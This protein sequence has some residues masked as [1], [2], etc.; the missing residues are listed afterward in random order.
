MKPILLSNNIKLATMS[1][2]NTTIRQ[3]STAVLQDLYDGLQVKAIL[4]HEE[5]KSSKNCAEKFPSTYNKK[6]RSRWQHWLDDLCLLCDSHRGGVTTTS[7]AV[8]QTTDGVAFWLAMNSGDLDET[9][10]HL[11]ALLDLV[12]RSR[13]GDKNLDRNTAICE[14]YTRAIERSPQRVKNYAKRLEN[15]LQLVCT[16]ADADGDCKLTSGT[17]DVLCVLTWARVGVRRIS[18]ASVRATR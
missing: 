2:A 3:D 1:H 12:K 18:V 8:E 7:V 15:V 16:G 6:R 10:V 13:E 14:I 9:S 4:Q 17:S 11:A 5:T